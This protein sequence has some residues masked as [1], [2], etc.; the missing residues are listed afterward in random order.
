MASRVFGFVWLVSCASVIAP[1]MNVVAEEQPAEIRLAEG[2]L[3]MIAPKEWKKKEPR[4]RIIQY[5]FSIAGPDEKTPAARVTI[6]G[7][8]GSVTA[9]VDRWKA[10]FKQVTKSDQETEKN[11]EVQVHL[12]DI[13]GTYR[14]RAGGP[15]SGAPEKL[16]PDYRMLGAIIVTPGKGQYFIKIIGPEKT[17]AKQDDALKAMLKKMKFKAGK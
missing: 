16:R 1:V 9:N 6:M 15:F 7:A 13:R 10:Q 12:I 4:F 14:E 5:E 11:G 2:A 3:T 8:G 17:L